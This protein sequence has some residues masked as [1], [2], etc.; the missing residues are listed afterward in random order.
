MG[1]DRV[2]ER[3]GFWIARAGFPYVVEAD[4]TEPRE[5]LPDFAAARERMQRVASFAAAEAG[6]ERV[7]RPGLRALLDNGAGELT[8]AEPANNGSRRA[9]ARSNGRGCR[10]A[11]SPPTPLAFSFTRSPTTSAIFHAR[12][13][14]FQMAEV[15]ISK[16]L[17]AEILRM[18][19]ELRPP[20]V[21]STG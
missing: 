9:R 7:E 14:A 5:P 8:S 13:V 21:A 11:P 3:F 2:D 16:N 1:R 10:A 12:Y 17:F 18:I 6:Q 15:V 19:A 20:P 4:P